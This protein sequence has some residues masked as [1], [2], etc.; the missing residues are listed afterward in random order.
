[1]IFSFAG[2]GSLTRLT[3]LQLRNGFLLGEEE[4]FQ[5]NSLTELPH[6]TDLTLKAPCA[7]IYSTGDIADILGRLTQLRR[8]CGGV[9][10]VSDSTLSALTDLRELT[11]LRLSD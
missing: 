4:V 6:L 2:L 11:H 10:R 5:L 1:M 8:L 9:W 3:S 7:C